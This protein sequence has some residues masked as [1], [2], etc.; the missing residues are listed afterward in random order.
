MEDIQL[1]GIFG[2]KIC[3]VRWVR[4]NVYRV[5]ADNILTGHI[6]RENG[7]WMLEDISGEL[8]T[9]ENVQLIGEKLDQ[10]RR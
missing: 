4:P 6:K 10:K 9:A 3:R 1:P 5:T 8:L 7:G 2:N